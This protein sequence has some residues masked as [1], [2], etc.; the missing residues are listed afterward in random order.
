MPYKNN[1]FKMLP[2]ANVQG[3]ISGAVAYTAQATYAAFQANAAQGELGVFDANSLAL[4]S[5]AG[6]ASVTADIFFA[7]MRDGAPEKTVSFRIGQVDM[8]RTA[9]S[10]QVKQISTISLGYTALLYLQDLLYTAKTPGAGG[11]AITVTNVVAGNSTALTIG[12]AANAITVNE[13]TSAGGVA[14][15]TAAQIAA[16]IIASGA[17]SALVN[18]VISGNA[19]TVQ[20]AAAA[21][22][23]VGGAANPVPTIGQVFEIGI[24]E[25]TPGN[26]PFPTYDYQ[27]QSVFGDTM[28]TVAANLVNQINNTT[29][30]ANANRDLIVT[31]LYN[32][33][34]KVI[35]ITAINFGVS[36][37]LLTKYDLDPI[38]AVTYVTPMHL[39]SGFVQEMQL[40]QDASD[41]YKGVTTNY[42]LQ[43]SNPADY[44][45][46]SDMVLTTIGYN[47]YAFNGFKDDVSKTPAHR[48]AFQRTI[49][50]GVPSTGATPDA[51]L[52]NIFGL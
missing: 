24:L 25:T 31:A 49:V 23:L 42:P 35:T 10:A 52:R 36:F 19:N 5:G 2:G 50:I 28:D 33:T 4:I 38:A 14:I 30:Y 16:A 6:A 44:G 17:A 9:Y 11:N 8:T 21:A 27:Y 18:V 39:G 43:G 46:P 15:S 34:T 3:G 51:Q 32:N 12:V 37:R 26:Q 22:N 45:K 47:I 41:I 48:Q 1:Y 20:V 7:I 29:N 40:F 13:A